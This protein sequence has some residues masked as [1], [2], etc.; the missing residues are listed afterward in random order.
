MN[1]RAS[2]WL[3]LSLSFGAIADV[4]LS[5]H[6]HI[7]DSVIAEMVPTEPVTRDEIRAY[8]SRFHLSEAITVTAV[9]LSN[10]YD[11][12][13]EILTVE[14][15]GVVLATLCTDCLLC[16][17]DEDCGNAD[18]V[19]LTPITLGA[20]THTIAVYD[21]DG[22]NDINFSGLTLVST[23]V[24]N[25]VNYIRRL[26]LGNDT[27][28]DDNYAN[29][30]GFY[31]DAPDGTSVNFGFNL[32]GT[33]T[34]TEIRFQRLR[35]LTP[36]TCSPARL[37]LDGSQIATL[38]VNGDTVALS[39]NITLTAGAHTL[40]VEPGVC[41]APDLDDF[42]FDDLNLLFVT[43]GGYFPGR[44]NA[45]DV[46]GSATAG[47]IKTKIG[48]TAFNL[49]I[50]ALNPLLTL[51]DTL[52]TGTVALSLLD[53]RN[54]S[55]TPDSNG[56]L[57]SW[58]TAQ[59]LGTTTFTALDAGRK[60]ISVTYPNALKVARIRAVDTVTG[61]GGCSTDT[62]A[63]RPDHFQVQANDGDASTAG[64]TRDLTAA[65]ISA[66]HPITH[67]AGRPF[68]LRVNARSASGT[69]LTNY[70]DTPSVNAGSLLL[71]SVTGALNAGSFTSSNGVA[72]SDTASYGEVGALV[73]TASD[74][75]FAATDASDGST[76]SERGIAGQINVGRFIPDTFSTALNTPRF[77]PGCGSFTYLGTPFAYSAPPQATLTAFNANGA[78]TQNY[79]GSL[80]KLSAASVTGKTYSSSGLTLDTSGLT[81]T[82]VAVV[83]AGGGFAIL[84]F[85][86]DAAVRLR[87]PRTT[88]TAAFDAEIELAANV[89]D[90]DGI[91]ANLRFGGTGTGTGIAFGGSGTQK[92]QRFGQLRLLN[93]YGSELL[94][95]AVPVRVEYATLL[96]SSLGFVT[97][98]DD[99]CTTGSAI[100]AAHATL[101]ESLLGAGAVGQTSM[102]GVSI[103]NG[104][105]NLSLSA[106]NVSG[107]VEIDPLDLSLSYPWLMPDTNDDGS[108]ADNP[109]AT[110]S[111]GLFQGQ[112]RRVY[113]REV[114]R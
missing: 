34:L 11:L 108:Y 6:L 44:F 63:I 95:L 57:S 64:L 19:L 103:S 56:C 100:S 52:Y 99:A 53:A 59:S 33:R 62:F 21:D 73:I 77:T 47:V 58:T 102:L 86:A 65:S 31:P 89:S 32:S 42:S 110:A 70:A 9:R 29:A 27:F 71:G 82:P 67:K 112:N 38:T 66:N 79:T 109:R 92:S 8:P 24:S 91:T 28:A 14:I 90:S 1:L 50:T 93:A 61:L 107:R 5:G 114:V 2:A 101:D 88:V 72:R 69:V 51:L 81:G 13:D 23:G 25:S 75:S 26:H 60:S 96:G 111:F 54:N 76:A 55:G 78:V 20:G 12:D 17:D 35:E 84:T 45:V 83:D 43:P 113:S 7:G 98:T 80:F 106:P 18:L 22:V 4:R 48:G 41:T 74:S 49:D 104:L 40:R 16:D 15:D 85:D 87:Y 37:L 30:S 97:S 46:G 94:D 68:T 36:A 39:T 105:G 10:A 3:L